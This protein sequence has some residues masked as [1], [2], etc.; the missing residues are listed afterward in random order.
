MGSE[1]CIRDSDSYDWG[2]LLGSSPDRA[3]RLLAREV[4]A[5]EPSEWTAI[6]VRASRF[7]IS[8]DWLQLDPSRAANFWAHVSKAWKSLRGVDGDFALARSGGAS[9][10]T[11]EVLV[12]GLSRV[13]AASL[14]S[15]TTT[16]R[17]VFSQLP[18][19][20]RTIDRW[21]LIDLSRR[22]TESW[23]VGASELVDWL[24]T[25]D[26]VAALDTGDRLRYA[27]ESLGRVVG[28]REFERLECWSLGLEGPCLLYTSPSPRDS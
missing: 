20:L 2:R 26:A 8:E 6:G 25:D 1:M 27:V 28:L 19:E 13:L 7:P 23:G 18:D 21:L 24:V 5:V 22:A 4:R 14:A 16:V 3:A 10:T 15:D 12:S 11:L 17:E 9:P